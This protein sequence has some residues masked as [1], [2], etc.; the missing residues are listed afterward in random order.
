[1]QKGTRTQAQSERARGED[2]RTREEKAGT[3]DE[4]RAEMS[5]EDGER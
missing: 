1:M 3:E 2:I 4:E 5:S